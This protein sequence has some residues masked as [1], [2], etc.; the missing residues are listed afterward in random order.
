MRL[1]GMAMSG[2]C[3]KVARMLRLTGSAFEPV[4]TDSEIGTVG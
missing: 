3:R 2:N 1:Y 4:E